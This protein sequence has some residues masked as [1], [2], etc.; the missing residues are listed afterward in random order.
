VVLAA[1]EEGGVALGRLVPRHGAR[2]P[3]VERH[4]EEDALFRLRL[5]LEFDPPGLLGQNSAT[6]RGLREGGPVAVERREVERLARAAGRVDAD[7]GDLRSV[8]VPDPA[9]D[10]AERLGAVGLVVV[11]LAFFGEGK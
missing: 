6:E 10:I 3:L 9:A 7:G 8:L 11:V 4:D 5:E 1:V 2:F